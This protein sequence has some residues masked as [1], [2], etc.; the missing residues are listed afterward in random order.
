ME[1]PADF[2]SMTKEEKMSLVLEQMVEE[3]IF[4]QVPPQIMQDLFDSW[5]AQLVG[6]KAFPDLQS[7]I[8]V[9]KEKLE[10]QQREKPQQKVQRGIPDWLKDLTEPMTSSRAGENWRE[11]MQ[12]SFVSI[13]SKKNNS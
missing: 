5:R 12:S 6:G 3:L 11:K 7:S 13:M 2:D 9:Y 4:Y 8:T 10:Q 1:L